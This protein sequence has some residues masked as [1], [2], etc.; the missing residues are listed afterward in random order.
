MATKGNMAARLVRAASVR[1][2]ALDETAEMLAI[3]LPPVPKPIRDVD[4]RRV[5]ESEYQT[6]VSLLV[7]DALRRLLTEG[8]G[9]G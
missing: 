5:L 3:E 9:D 6:K 8:N 1:K 7:R 2:E 4:M